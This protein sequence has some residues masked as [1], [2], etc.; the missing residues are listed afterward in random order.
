[1]IHRV[2]VLMPVY[3]GERFL[4]E[5]IESILS[6][7]YRDFEFLIIN[8]GSND[9][10]V[11]IV[12]SYH[13]PRIKL[14]HNE[15]N[16]GLITT[17]NKGIEI[18]EG[19]YIARMDAD[20]ISLPR[21]LEKQVS[22]MDGNPDVAVCGT[23]V[24]TFG[25]QKILWRYPLVPEAARC[26]LLFLPPVAHPS[27]IIR[28]SVLEEK[29]LRYDT[30]MRYAE[31]YDLW[32]RISEGSR[33]SNIGETLLKY[34]LHENSLSKVFRKGQADT[35][36]TIQRRLFERLGMEFSEDDLD[37][38]WELITLRF[39]PAE[40]FLLRTESW[41]TRIEKANGQKKIYDRDILHCELS[42]WWRSACLAASSLGLGAWR[43]FRS[44]GLSRY[45]DN[46][47]PL[48]NAHVFL[49]CAIGRW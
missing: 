37:H 45:R 3:N 24:E 22:F 32:V 49:M 46:L 30:G 10:S 1:M 44:A 33:I 25:A 8:D 40:G 17:L 28:K 42:Q 23:W 9:R 11:E 12:E 16:L 39:K 21:R 43:I 5:A 14:V 4:R 34:R 19:R 29:G 26:R 48:K 47:R 13:D 31:D 36:K 20:D 27:A 2:S 38:H 41:L 35:S 7:T 15:K 18:A 6:Q